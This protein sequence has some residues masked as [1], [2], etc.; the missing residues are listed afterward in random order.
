V[1]VL[2]GRIES[3]GD[4]SGASVAQVVKLIERP[5]MAADGNGEQLRRG[6][7]AWEGG[8]TFYRRVCEE[9]KLEAWPQRD[10]LAGRGPG[11]GGCGCQSVGDRVWGRPG[12]EWHVAWSAIPEGLA[13]EEGY[14]GRAH[15]SWLSR[16]PKRVRTPRRADT[17][18]QRAGAA[19]WARERDTVRCCWFTIPLNYL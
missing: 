14:G 7:P 10:V 19:V 6:F 4:S 12:W 9:R 3:L 13:R 5:L 1:E 8:A 17:A 11:G 15:A 2:C 16:R 18:W